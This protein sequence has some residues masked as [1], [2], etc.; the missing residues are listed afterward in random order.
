MTEL[1]SDEGGPQTQPASTRLEGK[2]L[3]CSHLYRG[4]CIK[5]WL[6]K[7][8]TS[9]LEFEDFLAQD[10]EGFL[11]QL[12]S[13]H[14]SSPDL[15]LP[16]LVL[17]GDEDYASM[18]TELAT[19]DG[20]PQT[21]PAS[22][23]FVERLE[24]VRIEE[25][26]LECSICLDQLSIGSEGRRDNFF[27]KRTCGQKTWIPGEANYSDVKN[28]T[29]PLQQHVKHPILPH[30]HDLA[31]KTTV[32]LYG[33]EF[34]AEH[35]LPLLFPLLTAPQLNVQQFAEYMCENTGLSTE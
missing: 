7:S 35:V 19:D 25:S 27:I 17:M 16:L 31:L 5:E 4:K 11:A 32:A 30:V 20:D 23:E 6:E 2:R 9:P 14:E 13:S 18:M 21:Q 22:A 12:A 28:I 10:L 15:L 33:V 8:K 24:T 29:G 1:A 26:G 3:L 34:V